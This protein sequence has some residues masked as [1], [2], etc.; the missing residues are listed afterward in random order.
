MNVELLMEKIPVT[1]YFC[2]ICQIYI[3]IFQ[4]ENNALIEKWGFCSHFIS[5]HIL[6]AV[7]K[8]PGMFVNCWIHWETSRTDG[9]EKKKLNFPE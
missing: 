7:H 9:D 6:S 1:I 5:Y 8:I 3:I 2:G 4:N